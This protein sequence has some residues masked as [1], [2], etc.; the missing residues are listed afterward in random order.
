M[1]NNFKISLL[2][3]FSLIISL[4]LLTAMGISGVILINIQENGLRKIMYKNADQLSD[5]VADSSVIHIENFSYY[6]L[7]DIT[8]KLQ[9]NNST[10]NDI[11][12]VQII[13][14]KGKLLNMLT[15]N[16][17]PSDVNNTNDYHSTLR[18][19]KSSS[20]S[21]STI[22]TVKIIFSLSTINSTILSMK[23]AFASTIILTTLFLSAL[24]F[25]LVSMMI[26]KPLSVV[27]DRA[28]QISNG[29]FDI[30]IDKISHDEIGS[31]AANFLKMSSDLKKSFAKI[32]TQK[33]EIENY[34][35]HLEDIITQR[36]EELKSAHDTMKSELVIAQR[37]QQ[38][39]IPK[40]F[41]MKDLFD[42]YGLYIPMENLGGDYYDIFRI[43]DSKIGIVIADVCGHGVPAALITTM[44]KMSFFNNAKIHSSSANVVS[45]VNKELFEVIGNMEYLTAFYC[46]IDCINGIM[47]YTNAGHTD[48]YIYRNK[49]KKIDSLPTNSGIIGFVES[50]EYKSDVVKIEE[51]DRV[52]FYTD[53]VIELR[54]ENRELF[55]TE[56]FLSLIANNHDKNAEELVKIIE[57]DLEH[58]KGAGSKDDDITLLIFDIIS[59]INTINVDLDSS[60]NHAEKPMHR[61]LDD[62]NNEKFNKLNTKFIEA[63]VLYKQSDFAKSV[64]ILEGIESKFNRKDDNYRVFY[65]LGHA[66]YKEKKIKKAIDVWEKA[67][68]LYPDNSEL[69]NIMEKVTSKFKES[70]KK[71]KE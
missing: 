24:I 13:S 44:T 18:E 42:M 8:K 40:K 53:G 17:I 29:N 16:R 23:I 70:V 68:K 47:E 6:A 32:E 58:Y 10:N 65:L 49:T 59:K 46:T 48:I 36:T 28:S 66:Y 34:N 37:I 15:S 63:H 56:R 57:S 4:F 69:L 12:S 26:T 54:D 14:L 22:G 67:L 62:D 21:Q 19:I 3:K 51:G 41:D 55:G 7:D 33:I 38:A 27:N 71:I 61:E 30:T 60:I 64:K 52:V 5:F 50:V 1:N 9:S 31:L 20:I 35:L 2:V 25:V 11:V 45:K 43:S 39:I